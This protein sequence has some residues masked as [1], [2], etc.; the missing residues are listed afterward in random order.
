[1]KPSMPSNTLLILSIDNTPLGMNFR[2]EFFHN[3]EG[4]V[5]HTVKMVALGRFRRDLL[6]GGCT[7][8]STLSRKSAI[9]I[10]IIFI[11]I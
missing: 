3:Q 11:L 8:L 2:D 6:L 10:N 9:G 4:V 5:A 1:M 7:T